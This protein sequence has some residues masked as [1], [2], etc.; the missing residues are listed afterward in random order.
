MQRYKDTDSELDGQV[1]EEFRLEFVDFLRGRAPA[2][3]Y[4]SLGWD[5]RTFRKSPEE[6]KNEPM[7]LHPSVIAYLDSH[8]DTSINYMRD[9]AK[10]KCRAQNTGMTNMSIDECYKLFKFYIKGIHEPDLQDPM[11]FAPAPKPG[12]PPA[13]YSGGVASQ[14]SFAGGPPPSAPS[15]TTTTTTPLNPSG[16]GQS[17]SAPAPDPLLQAEVEHL[18]KEKKDRDERDKKRDE[19]EKDKLE[20]EKGSVPNEE[21]ISEIKGSPRICSCCGCN[22]CHMASCSS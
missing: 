11:S 9:L 6:V 16:P 5:T 22:D 12:P 18:R 15:Q 1:N 14:I 10:L 20:G 7:S 19:E 2:E 3:M 21:I 4:E 13:G 8:V 17:L